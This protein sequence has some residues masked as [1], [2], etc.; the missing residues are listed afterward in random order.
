MMIRLL[1]VLI[2]PLLAACET[3]PP[4]PPTVVASTTTLSVSPESPARPMDEV[5]QQNL[6][7]NGDRQYGFASGCRIVV[8]PRRAV[9]KSE[10]GAC[11]LHH[12]DIA[13]LYASG[14]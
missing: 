5:P 9:V 2:L 4:A 6:L 3:A 14:D 11:E 12:R 10:T 8:E 1:P 13:L 7:A